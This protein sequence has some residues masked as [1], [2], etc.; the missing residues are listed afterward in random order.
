MAEKNLIPKDWR[1]WPKLD[2]CYH[3]VKFSKGMFN[4][5]TSNFV[6]SLGTSNTLLTGKDAYCGWDI[7]F[8]ESYLQSW[9][10]KKLRHPTRFRPYAK[11]FAN[12]ISSGSLQHLYSFAENI[13]CMGSFAK[14][15]L[16]GSRWNIVLRAKGFFGRQ[17]VQKFIYN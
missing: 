5:N 17:S 16:Q 8:L 12:S 1:Y 11:M 13:C 14:R 7:E 10:Y 4:P 15:A 9:W 3:T 6:R 2:T